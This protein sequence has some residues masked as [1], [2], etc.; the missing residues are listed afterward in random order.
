ML[1][2][3]ALKSGDRKIIPLAVINAA[4]H[5]YGRQRGNYYH[6][7]DFIEGAKWRRNN[8]KKD[9]RQRAF[10]YASRWV[11]Q[12]KDD[13]LDNFLEGCDFIDNYVPNAEYSIFNPNQNPN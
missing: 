11:E 5:N 2:K 13:A 10:K 12:V 1:F 4:S 3:W 7:D 6:S 8:P 9:K